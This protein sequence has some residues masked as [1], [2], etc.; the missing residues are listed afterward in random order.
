MKIKK[1]LT[2][3]A[4]SI[5]D[6]L[7]G[8]YFLE[9]V[10]AAYPEARCAIVVGSREAMIRDVCAAY[11][12]LEIIEV[13]RRNPLSVLRLLWQWCGSDIVLTQYAGK[14]G[15]RFSLA[16]KWVARLL[17]RHGGLIGF[18]DASTWNKFLYD[19]MLSFSKS[20][21]PAALERQALT[22]LGIPVTHQI[23]TLSCTQQASVLERVGLE[24]GRYAVVHL[25]AGNKGRGLSP[26]NQRVLV[27]ALHEQL[28]DLPLLVTGGKQDQT[29]AEEITLGIRNVHNIAGDVSLQE[30]MQLIASS[31]G[32]VSVDTGIAHIAAQLQKPLVVV[33]SCLGLHWWQEEQYSKR[34][35]LKVC[36]F[37]EPNGHVFK[38]YPDCLNN[39]EMKDIVQAT[40]NVF[41]A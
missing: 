3:R 9:N 14:T 36:T 34:I 18:A 27:S 38:E 8:K 13:N 26:K 19:N 20:A 1:A 32:V 23:P 24:S 17:A 28:P 5:G 40:K 4:A 21:A 29:Q 2:F 11:S 16:S 22:E 30:M 41:I 33:A 25:F 35:S 31:S 39:I 7:M 6:C 37:T 10:H 12:W 15:G